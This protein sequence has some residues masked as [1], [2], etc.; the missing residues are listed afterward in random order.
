MVAALIRGVLLTG[1]QERPA[2][3]L[4]PVPSQGPGSSRASWGR[5]IR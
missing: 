5:W 2:I 3:R 1:L 4:P